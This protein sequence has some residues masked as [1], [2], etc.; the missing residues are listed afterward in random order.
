MKTATQFHAPPDSLDRLTFDL[1]RFDEFDITANNQT[2]TLTEVADT[3]YIKASA[4]TGNGNV[5]LNGTFGKDDKIIVYLNNKT[6]GKDVFD[7][8]SRNLPSDN[9]AEIYGE[10][11][12]N[13]QFNITVNGVTRSTNLNWSGIDANHSA[14]VAVTVDY[15]NQVDDNTQAAFAIATEDRNSST[16]T[17]IKS[18]AGITYDVDSGCFTIPTENIYVADGETHG[19]VNLS[20]EDNLAV[21]GDNVAEQLGGLKRDTANNKVTLKT[22]GY[23]FGYYV[24]NGDG[25]KTISYNATADSV[26]TLLE[27]SGLN[28]DEESISSGRFIENHDNKSVILYSNY[29]IGDTVT[30]SNNSGGYLIYIG[31]GDWSG[32]TLNYVVTG[33]ADI[34]CGEF[35]GKLNF[36]DANGKLLDYTKK[37]SGQ[38]VVITVGTNSITLQNATNFD[39]LNINGATVST[40]PFEVDSDGNRLIQSAEDLIN[41]STYVTNGHTCDGLTFKLTANI[42]MTGKD[43][44]PIGSTWDEYASFKGTFNGAGHTISGLNISDSEYNNVGL[45]RFNF[46]TIKNLN[47]SGTVKGTY[48]KLGGFFV[49]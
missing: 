43:F 31:Y 25:G 39:T 15:L 19:T 37:V 29:L 10:Y 28:V 38:D 35:N 27:I 34:Y 20:G 5:T 13:T 3:I 45:F 7:W 4:F 30:V 11:N 42:D 17:G 33:N 47:V 48:N 22:E 16:L 2:V 46:G 21:T 44:T 40:S 8:T 12:G 26:E 36:I 14:T 23:G 1:Q 18:T 41:F 6:D 9:S 32:K 49:A 24:N